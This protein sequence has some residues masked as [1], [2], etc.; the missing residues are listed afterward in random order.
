MNVEQA[1]MTMAAEIKARVGSPSGA[2]VET[3]NNLKITQGR[4]VDAP[5]TG[6]CW[7]RSLAANQVSPI[8]CRVSAESNV[9]W[10]VVIADR[11][12][13]YRAQL[14][15][16][17]PIVQ[18]FKILV[19]LSRSRVNSDEKL[20]E[21]VKDEEQNFRCKIVAPKRGYYY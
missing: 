7:N 3:A 10:A 9:D 5:K 13:F 14:Y 1:F 11:E 2:G 15:T 19:F 4:D 21:T 20:E 12:S 18:H 8:Y 6:C 17:T 16:Y